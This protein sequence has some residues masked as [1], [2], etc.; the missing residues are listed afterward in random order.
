MAEVDRQRGSLGGGQDDQAGPSEP[1]QPL[2]Q[3]GEVVHVSGGGPAGQHLD[4]LDDRVE[5]DSP[6]ERLH[7]SAHA[8]P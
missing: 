2:Q 8:D 7:G 1:E 6:E 4:S 3:D 5:A